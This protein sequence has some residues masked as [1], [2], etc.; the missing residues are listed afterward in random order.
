[1][2]ILST[3]VL[4]NKENEI[5]KL[6]PIIKG[7]TAILNSLATV[8]APQN[9]TDKHLALLNSTSKL[10]SDIEGFRQIFTDPLIGIVGWEIT[11]LTL[12]YSKKASKT[13]QQSLKNSVTFDENEF[14]ALFVKTIQ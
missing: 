8:P 9:M 1:M 14:G 2:D 10:L 6:D 11:I 13:L 4:N 7:Y 5:E 12:N 3:A